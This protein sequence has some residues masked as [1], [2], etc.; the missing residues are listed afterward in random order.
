MDTAQIKTTLDLIRKEL[1]AK[2]ENQFNG[3]ATDNKVELDHDNGINL[4]SHYEVPRTLRGLIKKDDKLYAIVECYE[5]DDEN[6]LDD[7]ATEELLEL[8]ETLKTFLH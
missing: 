7:I 1:L 6:N 4:F 3:L 2:I 8:H 5:V